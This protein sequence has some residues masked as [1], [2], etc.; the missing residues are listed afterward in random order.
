MNQLTE[1]LDKADEVYE[2]FADRT[3]DGY[4]EAT[5]H[6]HLQ[7]AREAMGA[8]LLDKEETAEYQRRV[9]DVKRSEYLTNI[10]E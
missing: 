5:I 3:N 8:Y 9:Y 1:I 2:Y 7:L 10:T 6:Y 4:T